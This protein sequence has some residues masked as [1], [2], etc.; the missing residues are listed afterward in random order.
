M[1]QKLI[2]VLL[3]NLLSASCNYVQREKVNEETNQEHRIEE[4]SKAPVS[5]NST[6]N[7]KLQKHQPLQTK[8]YH[9][10]TVRITEENNDIGQYAHVSKK[11]EIE[12]YENSIFMRI[13][14][15]TNAFMVLEG[16]LSKKDASSYGNCDMYKMNAYE[17][18][19]ITICTGL[20][21]EMSSNGIGI[22]II[23]SG[24]MQELVNE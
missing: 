16:T 13:Y 2:Y 18:A 12:Y 22:F 9:F 15:E 14:G 17:D 5:P 3:C 11:V 4:I 19:S 7:D 8:T 6:A 20:P 10:N 1:N 24:K 21:N 23:Q